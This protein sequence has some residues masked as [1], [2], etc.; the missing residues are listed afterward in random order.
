LYI[1]YYSKGG[2]N[3]MDAFVQIYTMF[4]GG[5]LILSSRILA[6]HPK[7]RIGTI[8]SGVGLVALGAGGLFGVIE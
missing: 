3:D 4:M 7:L 6:I 2:I 5:A 8:L 1:L